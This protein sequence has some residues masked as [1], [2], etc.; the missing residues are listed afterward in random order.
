MTE[1]T[2]H[3]PGPWINT[4]L[5]I[6]NPDY[7]PVVGPYIWPN[8]ADQALIAAAPELLE[9]LDGIWWFIQKNARLL[10]ADHNAIDPLMEKA[11]AAIAKA[12]GQ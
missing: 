3:T 8:E 2:K 11:R 1:E 12:R 9:A 6:R 7:P 10:P 4:G 5:C